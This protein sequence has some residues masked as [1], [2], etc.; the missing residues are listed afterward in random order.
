MNPG[1]RG[2]TKTSREFQTN[3]C[4]REISPHFEMG[5]FYQPRNFITTLILIRH[6]S[7]IAAHKHWY[8]AGYKHAQ[9]LISVGGQVA[10][11]AM[12]IH[13]RTGIL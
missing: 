7:L 12:E 11:P 13:G 6:P 9:V 10:A 8:I 3:K 4:H 1:L 5:E 2:G